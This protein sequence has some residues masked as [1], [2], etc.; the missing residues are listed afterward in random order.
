[1]V[2]APRIFVTREVPETAIAHLLE[3][4]PDARIEMNREDRWLGAE[5]LVARGRG[6]NALICT[7]VDRIDRSVLTALAPDLKVVAAFAV[8]ID[9]IDLE[10][11]AELN[12]RVTNTPDVLTEATAEVA[13]GLI[14]ACSRRLVEGDRLTRAG[15]F[16]GWTPLFH[17]GHGVYGKT[18]GIIGAGRIGWRVAATMRRGFDCEILVHSTRRHRDWEDDLGAAFTPLDTL[19]ERS[20]FVSLHCPLTDRTRHLIDA[21]AISRMKPTACLVNTARG[22]VVDEIALVRAL[23]RGEIGAAGLDVYED[24]PRLAP[25]L[26]ALDNVVV[27]PHIGSATHEARDAM[28]RLCAEAVV[29]VLSGRDPVNAVV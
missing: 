18:L 24:E 21:T 15:R 25:G 26:S 6:A 16:A 28:G 22:A 9:N 11:A 27:L 13:V 19:L 4:L 8:G 1:M 14:L 17:R 7:L 23:E 10:A 5:E 2:D 20:D 12:V 29:D 3:S